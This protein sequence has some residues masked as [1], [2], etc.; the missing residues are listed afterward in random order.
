MKTLAEVINQNPESTILIEKSRDHIVRID[1]D[2]YG[3]FDMKTGSGLREVQ[4][5]TEEEERRQR[6]KDL[7]LK[8]SDSVGDIHQ[9]Y[10][11]SR[12]GETD[13]ESQSMTVTKDV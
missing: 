6:R 12:I 2:E 1:V 3:N 9:V 13:D 7:K 5:T 11:I 10:T 8:L 4:I